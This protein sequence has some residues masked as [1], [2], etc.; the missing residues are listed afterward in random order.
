MASNSFN[1]TRHKGPTHTADTGPSSNH[2]TG[3]GYFIY[4]QGHVAK[5]GD[6]TRLASPFYTFTR[7]HCFSFWYHMRGAAQRNALR[8]YL[9]FEGGSREL[10]WSQSG[11]KGDQWHRGE[12]SM[13]QGKKAQIIVEGEPGEDVHSDVAVDDFS[14]EEGDCPGLTPAALTPLPITTTTSSSTAPPA[15]EFPLQ[16]KFPC[17]FDEGLCSW[18]QSIFDTFDWVRHK[19]PTASPGTGPS[20]DH[21]SGEGYYIYLEVN[22]TNSQEVA[23]LVSSKCSPTKPQ[24]LSFWYH[25]YGTSPKMALR[26][27]VVSDIGTPKLIWSQ[28][29]NKGNQ[30]HRG[31]V[32][33]PQ[34]RGLQI[35]LEGVWGENSQSVVAVDDL[36]IEAEDCPASSI[37][38]NFSCSFDVDFCSWK[39]LA[40]NA[41][42]WRRHKGP[43]PSLNTGPTQDHTSGEGHFIYL[44][45]SA[46]NTG[47]TTHLVSPVCDSSRPHCLRFWYHM[48]GAAQTM[49]LRIL[50]ISG[51]AAPVLLWSQT[52]NKGD[53]WHRGEVSVAHGENMQIILEGMRGEDVHSDMAVDDLSLEEGFC[54]GGIA[55]ASAHKSTTTND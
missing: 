16:C 46:T 54:P 15:T 7:P 23:R 34:G 2:T 38:C 39:Q 30:W 18:T 19:G 35:F 45:G 22:Q 31:E 50:V 12:V 4:L 10:I 13:P 11:N 49:A 26:V 29:G 42:N 32:S 40:S 5:E 21:T 53:Q 25:M 52:G 47:D 14:M 20:S 17:S 37:R 51:G 24:C 41:F 36:S 33:V 6:A 43:T 44:D 27:Y 1:W 9:A 55:A 48:Y 28:T 8:V 3:E